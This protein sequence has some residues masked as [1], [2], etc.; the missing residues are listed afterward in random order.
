VDEEELGSEER[1][2]VHDC[3]KD[4]NKGIYSRG[5]NGNEGSYKKEYIDTEEEVLMMV[6][7]SICF[8]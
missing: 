7:E 5:D 1:I 8:L 4:D 2:E 6:N 3:Y